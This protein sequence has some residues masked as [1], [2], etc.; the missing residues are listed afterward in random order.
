M[1]KQNSKAFPSLAML[2]LSASLVAVPV[3][4][5]ERDE[6][7]RKTRVI[8]GPQLKPSYPGSDQV[9]ISP[10][11]DLTRG[12]E[13]EDFVFVAPDESFG[14]SLLEANG[15]S[16]GPSLGFEGK[17]SL[18]DV[19]GTL[20]EVDFTVELGGFVNYQA[21]EN[22]RLRAEVRQA[23]NG[24]DGLIGV[25]S[26][27]YIMRDGDKHLL[28]IGPRVTLTDQTYQESYFSVLPSQSAISGLAAY[29]SDGGVQ[30]V[31]G[32]IS[33]LRQLSTRWGIYSY[34]NYERLIGDPA[35]SPVVRQFGSRDQF[36]GGIALSYTFGNGVQ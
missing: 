30:A 27:D 20:P 17:R 22:I 13:G 31:G 8:L 28:S 5:Q 25:L 16:L 15:F 4:A 10:L 1:T 3:A 23:V 29:D 12:R 19:D 32:T 7:A 9:S 11:V 36:S 14:F 33:Y 35:D 34:A 21:T 6:G 26:A 2:L 24:H 18:G